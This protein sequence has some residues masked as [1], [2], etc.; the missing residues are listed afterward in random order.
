M[1]NKSMKDKK[2]KTTQH[3][4][5]DHVQKYIDEIIEGKKYNKSQSLSGMR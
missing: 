1:K 5:Q 4:E 2:V 3:R